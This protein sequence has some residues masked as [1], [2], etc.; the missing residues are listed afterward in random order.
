[1][2]NKQIDNA[3]KKAL[4]FAT[5]HYENF[6]VISLFVKKSL[7]KHIA[8]IYWFAR[9]ADDIADEGNKSEQQRLNELNAFEQRLKN[10]IEGT[11]QD[12]FDA[13][14]AH[15]INTRNLSTQLFFDLLKAFRQDITKHTFDTFDEILFYCKHSANP[16]GRLILELHC[17]FDNEAFRLS[18]KICT[19]LQL[20]NFYQDISI[21]I[22]KQRFYISL[23]EL[24]KFNVSKD[25]LRTTEINNN[26]RELLT[27]QIDRTEQM[28]IDGSKILHFLSGRLKL[29]ISWTILGG[30]EILNKIRAMNYAITKTRPKLTKFEFLTLFIKSFGYERRISKNNIEKE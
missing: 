8:I 28:F 26:V 25:D 9:T 2:T 21:D 19:A 5:S 11:Y 13:A 4:N 14:L 10:C 29:E 16:V 3:Y 18:D 12:D 23:D 1:M 17:I 24:N 7:R 30:M 20:T 6:P 27:F 15:T 22:E